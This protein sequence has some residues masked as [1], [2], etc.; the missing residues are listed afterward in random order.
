MRRILK[1][2]CATWNAKHPDDLVSVDKCEWLKLYAITHA[3]IRHALSGYDQALAEG[4]DRD[5]L[6]ERISR[7]ACR[8]YPWLRSDTDPRTAAETEGK[9][10]DVRP[11]NAFSKQLSDLAAERARLTLAIKD[12]R[13]HRADSWREQVAE[14]EARLALVNE[15]ADRLNT[16]FDASV[17]RTEEGKF[18]RTLCSIQRTREYDFARASTISRAECYPNRTQNRLVSSVQHAAER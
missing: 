12:A 3:F 1:D 15:R 11:Y 16:F 2:A 17:E 14:L 8:A 9:S 18:V 6:Q 5:E 7:A 10:E 4:A 13:R